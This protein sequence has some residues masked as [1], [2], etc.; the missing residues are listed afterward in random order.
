MLVKNQTEKT[1][2]ESPV[3]LQA[4]IA[5]L[6][7]PLNLDFLEDRMAEL[8]KKQNSN[9][10]KILPLLVVT[11][12]ICPPCIFNM[13][14]YAKLLNDHPMFFEPTI[15]FVEVEKSAAERFVTTTDLDIPFKLIHR[16][17]AISLF[18]EAEQNLMFVDPTEQV[19]FH[20]IAIPNGVTQLEYKEGELYETVELWNSRFAENAIYNSQ[21]PDETFNTP[22]NP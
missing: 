19:V 12:K 22:N 17:D 3:E 14:D 18:R 10:P 20:N 21:E 6:S 13:D 16:E 8:D 2:I 15:V 4:A 5:P 9:E 11:T 1:V 7:V